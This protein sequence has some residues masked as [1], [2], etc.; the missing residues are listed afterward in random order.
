MFEGPPGPGEATGVAGSSRL[1]GSAWPARRQPA[2]SHLSPCQ[3]LTAASGTSGVP[4][5]WTCAVRADLSL[6]QI[7]ARVSAPLRSGNGQRL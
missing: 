3:L 6:D 2:G 7:A 1:V 4:S 5:I